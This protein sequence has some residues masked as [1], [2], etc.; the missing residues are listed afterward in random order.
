[1]GGVSACVPTQI[2]EN[3]LFPLFDS[4][5]LKNFVAATVVSC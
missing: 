1:M 5:A 3:R 4:E 2:D